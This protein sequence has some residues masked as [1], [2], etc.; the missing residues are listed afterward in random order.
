MV[1][2]FGRVMRK[3]TQKQ[4]QRDERTRTLEKKEALICHVCLGV[5][6]FSFKYL[7]SF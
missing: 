2:A 1:K 4:E 6:E 5:A 3:I 7:K